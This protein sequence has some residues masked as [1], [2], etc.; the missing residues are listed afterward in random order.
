M[1]SI[2]TRKADRTA[3][4]RKPI[5]FAVDADEGADGFIQ[6]MHMA[7]RDAIVGPI[8]DVPDLPA[9]EV[10]NDAG[11]R[12]SAESVIR[13][14]DNFADQTKQEQTDFRQASLALKRLTTLS[15]RTI[16]AMG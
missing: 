1:R 4:R 9:I 2:R 16:A 10:P 13:A 3:T 15:T 5:S 7:L 6:S 12:G 14:D 11:E 8:L